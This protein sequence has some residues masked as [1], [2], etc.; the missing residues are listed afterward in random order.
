MFNEILVGILVF[1]GGGLI[2]FYF[3]NKIASKSKREIF[4]A[5]DLTSYEEPNR[6]LEFKYP[7]NLG[8]ISPWQELGDEKSLSLYGFRILK[9]WRCV[10]FLE[11][12]GVLVFC[13]ICICNFGVQVSPICI[14]FYL[15]IPKK[16]IRGT[17]F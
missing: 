11:K 14:L 8:K 7:A 12:I 16:I 6:V 4:R 1:V 15:R 5:P 2:L 17:H 10:V 9:G 13:W 3:K